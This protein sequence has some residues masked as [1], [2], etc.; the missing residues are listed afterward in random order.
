MLVFD[1]TPWVPTFI[2]FTE[3]QYQGAGF[4]M[5]LVANDISCYPHGFYCIVYL[6]AIRTGWVHPNVNL[7]NPEKNVVL[8]FLT[9]NFPLLNYNLIDPISPNLTCIGTSAYGMVGTRLL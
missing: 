9:Q 3:Q 2:S 5:S 7:D 6:Q 1:T 4:I 8:F